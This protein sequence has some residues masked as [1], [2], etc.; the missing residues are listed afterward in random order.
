MPEF[1]KNPDGMKPSGYKMKY[2]NSAF[3]FKGS[4][5]K[6]NKYTRAWEPELINE[7]KVSM[8]KSQEEAKKA[9]LR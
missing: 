3:P 9:R 5:A 4:P 6:Y 2:K 1:T 7:G 8:K